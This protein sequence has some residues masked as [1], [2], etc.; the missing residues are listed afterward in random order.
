MKTNNT[1]TITNFNEYELYHLK[2]EIDY[3]S[4]ELRNNMEY[5]TPEQPE[6]YETQDNIEILERV[7]LLLDELVHLQ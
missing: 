5:M 1:Y 7:I 3:I 2:S 6:Y 4:T